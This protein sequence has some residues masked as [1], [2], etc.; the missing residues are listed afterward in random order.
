MYLS[1]AMWIWRRPHPTQ[2]EEAFFFKIN[3]VQVAANATVPATNNLDIL[4]RFLRLD[5]STGN[6]GLNANVSLTSEE[7][8]LRSLLARPLSS[9]VTVSSPTAAVT[10]GFNAAATLFGTTH[11]GSINFSDTNIFDDE[12]IQVSL[13]GFFQRTAK[14]A[15][16][17]LDQLS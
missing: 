7:I 17:Q 15:N 6:L 11:S 16:D 2:S 13:V 9:L 14:P 10:G 3:D 1:K 5:V 4:G 8:T 12:P